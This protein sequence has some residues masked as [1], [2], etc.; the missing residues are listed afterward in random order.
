MSVATLPHADPNLPGDVLEPEEPDEALEA[1]AER[2]AL[3]RR[4]LA[5]AR[6]AAGRVLVVLVVLLVAGVGLWLLSV[7]AAQRTAS[8]RASEAEVPIAVA[9]AEPLDEVRT[10]PPADTAAPASERTQQA[11]SKRQVS[12]TW[13]QQV[14]A[15]TGIPPRAV[16][17]Y[18]NAQLRLADQAPSCGLSWNTLAAIGTVESAN[19][20][21]KGTVLLESGRTSVPIRGPVLN[22]SGVGAVRDTDNGRW[23]GNTRW[24]RALGPMQFIPSTWRKWAADGNGDGVAD[25]D[26]IDD[27]ALTAG[28]YLCASGRMNTQQGWLD[29]VYAYNHS[30]AYV[31]KVAE[32][33][34]AYAAQTS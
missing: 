1:T 16:T 32:T 20:T 4:R 3:W 17:A 15:R 9:A 27:A 22:G 24:D 23:D 6:A 28:R 11:T 26:Q 25:P 34:N 29:G 7:S 31:E 33:A 8:S 30:S 18:A 19:G 14:A 21:H 12:D 13:V 10:S 2:A 5:L